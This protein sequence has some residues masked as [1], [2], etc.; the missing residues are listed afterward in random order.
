MLYHMTGGRRLCGQIAVQGSKNAALPILFA[1]LLTEEPVTLLG[2]PDIADVHTALDILS[3]MGTDIRTEGAGVYTLTARDVSPPPVSVY[4]KIASIRASSYL[5]GAGLARFGDIRIP[6]PGGCDFGSRPLD[7]HKNGFLSLG[8]VWEEDAESIRVSA[9]R[10]Q[11]ARFSMPYPSVGATVNFLF[12]ALGANGDSRLSGGAS[13]RHVEDLVRFLR[14]LGADITPERGG[15]RIS[16]GKLHGGV[17]TVMPDGIEAGTYLIG[18]AL[19]G[20]KTKCAP[21]CPEEMAPLRDFLT[22]TGAEC[23][24]RENSFTVVSRRRFRP[25]AVEC[26]PYPGFPTDLQPPACLLLS[27]AGG[28]VR[29]LVWRD[30]FAYAK[31]AEKMGLRVNRAGDTLVILPSRLH[32]ACV[33]APDLRGGA[34]LLVAALAAEGETTLAEAEKIARGYADPVGKWSSLGAYIR[35]EGAR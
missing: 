16:G 5:L 21:V 11:G 25:T 33:R 26:L 35:E 31:E 19:C 20:G 32:G 27:G 34:A 12:A 1:C 4:P 23:R 22:R 17:Y 2:V 14:V 15:A 29:D 3:S 28:Q 13:E 18:T 7:I 10:L 9:D 30:R 24:L 8:A 6:H